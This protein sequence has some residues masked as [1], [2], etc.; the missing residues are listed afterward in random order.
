MQEMIYAGIER[1]L[2]KVDPKDKTELLRSLNNHLEM[3]LGSLTMKCV[4]N[5]R[6][7]DCKEQDLI[8]YLIYLL[9]DQYKKE[10]EMLNDL[11]Y[12]YNFYKNNDITFTSNDLN[13]LVESYK[14]K[15]RKEN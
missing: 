11:L 4:D 13:N 1:F 14:N 15:L 12:K 2:D 9:H 3:Y 6:W 7:C 5:I 8:M 10:E